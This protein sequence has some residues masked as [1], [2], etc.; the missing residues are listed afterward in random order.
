MT[1]AD[2]SPGI[3]NGFSGEVVDADNLPALKDALAEIEDYLR[4]KRRPLRPLYQTRDELQARIAELEPI[5]LPRRR[6][7]T[8][9]QQRVLRCSRCKTIIVTDS[10]PEPQAEARPPTEAVSNADKQPS[11]SE[12]S[13][14]LPQGQRTAEQEAALGIDIF[15][16]KLSPEE[17]AAAAGPAVGA[18]APVPQQESLTAGDVPDGASPA[19]LSEEAS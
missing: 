10:E 5:T 1:Q 14:L 11:D 7:Q 3:L 17:A 18:E 13:T 15:G 2:F 16:E 12:Q 9:K 6:N 8:D 19:P 4:E